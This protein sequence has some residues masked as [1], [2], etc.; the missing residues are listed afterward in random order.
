MSAATRTVLPARKRLAGSVR[1]PGDKSIG[2]RSVLFNAAAVGTATI[3]GLPDGADVCSSVDAMRTLGCKVERRDG[4]VTIEG[5]AL[6]FRAP[7]HAIDCGNSG[8]TMRL[9]TGLLA[10]SGIDVVLDGDAS[11]RRRPMERV[12]RPLREMGAQ[13]ETTDGRAPIRIA[14][15]RLRGASVKL[16]VAS[17]QLKSAVLLAALSTEGRTEVTEP[18]LS[19]DHS[20]RMLASMGVAIQRHR[21]TLALRGPVIPRAVDVS[22]CGDSSSSAFFAVAAAIVRDS[23]V[24]VENVCLNPTRT[25]FVDVLRRMG[26]NIETRVTGD[27]AGEPVGS[28]RVRGDAVLR[29][30]AIGPDDVPATIDELPVLA[31]AAALARGTT[32]IKGAGELRV[33]ESDRI[34]TV[35]DMLSRLG[36]RVEETPDGMRIEG[37]VLSGG[38]RIATHG[39]HRLVMAAAVAALAC[40]EAVEIE[41]PEAAGVSFPAFFRTLEE[42][43]R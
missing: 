41:E 5:C 19:R 43:M 17:A 28:I 30:V 16:D 29:A 1:V 31:V 22:V 42:V 13:I 26:A 7:D 20:E 18:A 11:L 32:V 8:T 3:R 12:A 34:A 4:V 36:A 2:H 15:A 38:A 14:S 35:A 40:E 37:G 39:D 24:V 27:V 10:G 23:D 25:G 6:R 33:K 21:T 9:L